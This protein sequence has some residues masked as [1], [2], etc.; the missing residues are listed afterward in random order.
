MP[1]LLARPSGQERAGRTPP[2]YP[3]SGIGQWEMSLHVTE[4]GVAHVRQIARAYLRYWD[5]DDAG[6]VALLGLTE[7]LTNVLKHADPKDARILMQAGPDGVAVTVSDF[8]ACLPVIKPTGPLSE[9]GRGLPLLKAA[10]D[11]F[12]IAPAPTGKDVWFRV[13]TGPGKAGGAG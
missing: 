9:D 12:G 6:D 11:G 13:D 3:R 7:L 5:L 1:E 4:R 8:D 10:A 2:S